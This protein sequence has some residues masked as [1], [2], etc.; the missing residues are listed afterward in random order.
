MFALS[1]FA[2]EHD[3]VGTVEDGVGD[4]ADF[5]AGGA[6]LLDHGFEHFGG[7]DDGSRALD[8]FVDHH[9]LQDGDACRAD[10][11]AEVSASDHDDVEGVENAVDVG[12]GFGALDLG[13]D[14]DVFC[15]AVVE[16]DVADGGDVA[17]LA[18]E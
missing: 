7:D 2:R 11:D 1:G 5:G 6:A 16:E 4:V 10:L 14:G 18:D 17:G 3:G 15:V 13:D 8:G 12:D 9:L